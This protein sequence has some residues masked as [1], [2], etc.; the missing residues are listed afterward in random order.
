MPA[1]WTSFV[2]VQIVLERVAVPKFAPGISV[3]EAAA[4]RGMRQE[5]VMKG[6]RRG[7]VNWWSEGRWREEVREGVRAWEKVWGGGF[8]VWVGDGVTVENEG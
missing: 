8:E 2:T 5:V 1:V 4:E 3:Q 6:N 7:W